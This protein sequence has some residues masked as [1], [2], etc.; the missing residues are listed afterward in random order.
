MD[1]WVMDKDELKKMA[2]QFLKTL[3]STEELVVTNNYPLKGAFPRLYSDGMRN[4]E[5]EVTSKEIKDAFFSMR[6]LKTL[7]PY[8]FHAMF[9]QS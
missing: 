8:G 6:A 9:F 2:T 3:Y 4:I 1:S 5:D 7:G